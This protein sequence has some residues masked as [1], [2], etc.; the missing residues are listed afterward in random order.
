MANLCTLSH[1]RSVMVSDV[2]KTT[3]HKAKAMTFK[4]KAKA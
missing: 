2:N 1:L 4:A 3:T